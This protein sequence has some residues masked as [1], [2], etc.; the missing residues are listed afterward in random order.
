MS[1]LIVIDPSVNEIGGNCRESITTH[2]N[3]YPDYHLPIHRYLT[4]LINGKPVDKRD[5]RE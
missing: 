5:R 4:I 3:A 2:G 1:S